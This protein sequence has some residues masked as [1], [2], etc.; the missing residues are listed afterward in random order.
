MKQISKTTIFLLILE[1][2]VGMQYKET[3]LNE[4]YRLD[5]NLSSTI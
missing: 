3:N 2:F 4:S 1:L 5:S